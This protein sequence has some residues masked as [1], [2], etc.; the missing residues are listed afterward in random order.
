MSTVPKPRHVP[1]SD[2]P[3]GYL[4]VYPDAAGLIPRVVTM[5]SGRYVLDTDSELY[6]WEPI[7]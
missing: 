5:K 6:R 4:N 2:G 7:T 1:C 3:L